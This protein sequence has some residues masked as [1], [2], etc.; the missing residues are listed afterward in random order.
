METLR[1]YDELFPWALL[2][3]VTTITILYLKQLL[4]AA[5]KRRATSSPSLPCPRGLPLIGNLHQLGTTPHDALAALAAK[6][7]APVMLLRLGSVR[8]LVVS[9]ADAL[10][11]VFQPNDRAMSGRPALCAATRITYGLQDIVF[12]PPDGGFWRTAR[13]AS[14]SE[15]LSAPRVRS[16][17]DVREQEAAALVAAVTDMSRSGSPVNLSEELMETSNKILRRVAFGD[18]GG[19]EESI[20]AS[21]VLEETQKLLGGF[22][23]ADYMPWLGWLDA[24]RGLRR[25]LERNFHELDAFYE[26]V[27]DDHLSKRGDDDDASKGEDLVDVL[28]RLHGDPAYQSTFNSRDQIKGILTDMFIAG[29]DTAAATVEWTMTELVRHPDILAKAQ[30]EVRGAVAGR[31]DDIVRESDLPRLKYLK[32]VIREAM[33]VHPPVPLLVPRETIE[34]CTVYGCEIPAR[35]RVFVNAKAIGQDPDAWGADAARFVP[36]RHEEIADLSDHKP[37]HDSFSLVPFGVGRRSCPGVH[38]ATSVVELLLAN[39]LFCFDWRAPHGG[40]VDLEQETG[41]TVHRKHPLV[42]VARRVRVQAPSDDEL[43]GRFS[44]MH[45]VPS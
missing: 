42:L 38:F 34:P 3:L 41:L 33:R 26:K 27:I 37:W 22:F 40:V 18:G 43:D 6:H 35:T 39:L 44:A 1:A 5:F 2:V 15:L 4:V 36:E 25:R 12:S 29:T 14:L 20:R 32:Q 45:S 17:R 13:R 31:D 19:E 8:T 11:A 21:A 7:A 28:L 24:L 9:T 23:V 16:F 30:K 10:R